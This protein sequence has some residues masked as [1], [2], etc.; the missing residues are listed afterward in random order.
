MT[1]QSQWIAKHKVNIFAGDLSSDKSV[2]HDSDI[3]VSL[4]NIELDFKWN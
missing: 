3:Y 4:S 2:T 1:K